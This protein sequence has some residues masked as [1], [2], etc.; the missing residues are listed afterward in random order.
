M[1]ST[2][3]R[4][5]RVTVMITDKRSEPPL[6]LAHTIEVCAYDVADALVQAGFEAHQQGLFDPSSD[7]GLELRVANVQP[8]LPP[9]STLTGAAKGALDERIAKFLNGQGY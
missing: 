8:S 2:E 1:S 3:P 7:S 5:Y 4:G 9:Y 6:T